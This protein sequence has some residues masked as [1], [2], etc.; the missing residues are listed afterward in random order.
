MP[1]DITREQREC[2]LREYLTVFFVPLTKDESEK[3][4]KSI[5]DIGTLYLRGS[6]SSLKKCVAYLLLSKGKKL[7]Y[8]YITTSQLLSSWLGKTSLFD[9]ESEENLS[10]VDYHTKILILHNIK[11]QPPNKALEALVSQQIAER[12]NIGLIT[13]FLD[14]GDMVGVRKSMSDYNLRICD[15]TADEILVKRQTYTDFCPE[16]DPALR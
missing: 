9:A 4:K 1:I 14:E 16:E 3:I 12:A 13:L 15:K 8:R 10:H 11:Y 6:N 5:G 2:V 7:E